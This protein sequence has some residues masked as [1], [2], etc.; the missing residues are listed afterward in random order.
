[1]HQPLS[2]LC[3]G[4]AQEMDMESA[5]MI[6]LYKTVIDVYS[7]ITEKSWEVIQQDILNPTFISADEAKTY[8]L[9]DVVLYEGTTAWKF[10]TMDLDRDSDTAKD[11]RPKWPFFLDESD[12]SKS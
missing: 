9:I 5:E 12:N 8:G 1:M 4:V 11:N 3:H 6:R 10:P 7:E 2:I